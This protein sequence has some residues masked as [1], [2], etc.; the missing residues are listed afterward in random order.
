MRPKI[1]IFGRCFTILGCDL[2]PKIDKNRSKKTKEFLRPPGDENLRRAIRKEVNR[3][4]ANRKVSRAGERVCG[5]ALVDP[6]TIENGLL[7]QTLKQRRERISDRDKV[8]IDLIYGRNS[9]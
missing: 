6:F 5:V 9:I 8:F 1:S 7:T 4:L 3:M 2:E